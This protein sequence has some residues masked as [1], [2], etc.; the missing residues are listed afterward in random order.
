MSSRRHFPL[1]VPVLKGR[2][3]ELRA[4]QE[5]SAAT[6]ARLRP[7]VEVPPI[8]WD[9]G[10]D[11]P[12]KTI[13]DH[14]ST[15]GPKMQRCWGNEPLWIDLMWI[16]ADERL[17][18]GT[19]PVQ[20]ILEVGRD[21]GL[22]LI[23]TTSLIRDEAYQHSVREAVA[24]DKRGFA[25]RVQLADFE[26]PEAGHDAMDQVCSM[27]ECGPEE[28]DLVI[29]LG[30]VAEGNAP[31][32]L[33]ASM[34]ILQNLRHAGRWRTLALVGGS[35]PQ[36]LTGLAPDDI[37]LVSREE[38]RLWRAVRQ[39]S[40]VLKQMPSFGDYG[41]SHP[42]PSEVDPRI[43]RPSASV[44]YTTQDHWLVPKGRNLRA[45]GFDQYHEVC[46]TLVQRPEYSGADF[47]W[48][49]GYI[50]NC[51]HRED[52]PGNLTTWRK[53]GTSHHLTFVATALAN[54]SAS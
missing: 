2:E 22:R 15:F 18:N 39:R 43:M 5:L 29:D 48:G 44:R 46:K 3:G 21:V 41:I 30:A 35:F 20:E 27:L 32:I 37:S 31:A 51:A 10:E 19:H 11:E 40:A 25:L 33:V 12:L 1:Y 54:G 16:S 49:D 52:G 17:A 50:W 4:L 6:R 23:P 7:I 34:S 45:H 8:P 24:A 42:E 14:L 36:N 38:W 9:Y 13:D 47:S 53:V 26:D 28:T